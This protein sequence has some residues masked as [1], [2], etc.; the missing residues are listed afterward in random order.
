[1]AANKRL[2]NPP[3]WEDGARAL[4]SA[5]SEGYLLDLPGLR[6]IMVDLTGWNFQKALVWRLS[7]LNLMYDISF[8]IFAHSPLPN[9]DKEEQG[10]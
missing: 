8:F 2:A 5:T 10:N 7:W 4:T 9:I 6:R 3:V 1:M